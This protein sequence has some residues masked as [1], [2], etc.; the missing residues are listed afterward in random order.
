MV[1]RI[2][3]SEVFAQSS[4]VID[5]IFVSFQNIFVIFPSDRFADKE[6]DGDV[7]PGHEPRAHKMHK[8]RYREKFTQNYKILK[9]I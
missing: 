6:A 4:L 2:S 9:L 8:R 5:H 3:R 7:S 1:C